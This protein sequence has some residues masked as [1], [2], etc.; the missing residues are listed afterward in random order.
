[1]V[2][3]QVTLGQTLIRTGRTVLS[4][5]VATLGPCSNSST[6]NFPPT[7]LPRRDLLAAYE[8][9]IDSEWADDAT[10]VHYNEL[11]RRATVAMLRLTWVNTLVAMAALVIA[12]IA[13]LK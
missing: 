12:L 10:P 4:H 3:A 2:I 6:T 8:D 5:S 11:M 7:M 9:E 13:L 1:M